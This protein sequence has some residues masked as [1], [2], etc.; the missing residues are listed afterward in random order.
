MTDDG[1]GI[2][3]ARVARRMLPPTLDL[4]IVELA[5][6]GLG[7][8]EAM[9]GYERV[10]VLDAFW[11]PTGEPGRVVQFTA[12]NLPSTMN[13]ASAHDVDL[14]AAMA[15]GRKL[16]ASLPSD[17]DV[18]IVAVQARDVLTFG[19]RPTQA[20]LDA[21]P[22]VVRRVGDI[23]GYPPIE[24]PLVFDEALLGGYDDIS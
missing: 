20:V 22:E 7:L 12:A 13:T 21:I 15:V 3:A 8:M 17:E 23:L 16:G 24:M 14:P 4:D 18:L 2:Y 6:G 11:S 19:D 5:V 1:V 9:I 10:I